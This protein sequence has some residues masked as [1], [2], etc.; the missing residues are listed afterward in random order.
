MKKY[1]GLFCAA[2]TLS[3][4]I[5]TV[6]G[7]DEKFSFTNAAGTNIMEIKTSLGELAAPQ[8]VTVTV[9]DSDG[10]VNFAYVLTAGL[11]GKAEIS[12]INDGKS[13]DYTCYFGVRGE[14]EPT[15][16]KVE[17]FKGSEFWTAYIADANQYAKS[18][19]AVE[20]IKHITDNDKIINLNLDFYN[21][22]ADKTAVEKIILRDY[23]EYKQLKDIKGV[24][25][26]SV[27]V[28]MLN[29]E[30]SKDVLEKILADNEKTAYLDIN[31]NIPVGENSA[32]LNELSQETRNGILSEICKTAYSSPSEL[33]EAFV[34]KTLFCGIKAAKNYDEVKRLL[35]AY[36]NAGKIS[37]S[38]GTNV[39]NETAAFKEMQGKSYGSYKD[40]ENAYKNIVN[41]KNSATHGSNSGGGGGGGSYTVTVKQNVPSENNDKPVTEIKQETVHSGKMYF[42]DIEDSKW[43]LQ[44]INYLYENNI[45]NGNDNGGFEP[46]RDVMRQEFVKM[47][48]LYRNIEVGSSETPFSDVDQNQWYAPY[49]A[50]AYKNKVF[51]GYDDT[52][53]G[54]N[55]GITRQ[56]AV[57]AVYR[58]MVAAGC[59]VAPEEGFT[60]KD[61]SAIDEWAKTAVYALRNAGI[62]SG[63]TKEI[64]S[65]KEQ[66][67]RAE[68]AVL[69]YNTR[70][71][72]TE[73]AE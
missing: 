35:T 51:F 11:D 71:Y 15:V 37:V 68:A 18:G 61:D 58:L 45:I 73:K 23:K 48:V 64:F 29:A 46:S 65:P 12:Y 55:H 8:N 69:I 30:P 10:A 7:Q 34:E 26:G 52:T 13:G 41:A 2:V 4:S 40:V 20:L 57:T 39:V 31:A 27:Y 72:F 32:V 16:L 66:M 62:I 60:F 53:F 14:S 38:I 54:V 24:F 59:D 1:I 33:T 50:A 6:N 56:E 67:T 42:N 28:A 25:G 44:A 5:C 43:A 22:L 17:D 9:Y 49:I 19:N 3:A 21:S 36:G 63:R 47:L 70:E